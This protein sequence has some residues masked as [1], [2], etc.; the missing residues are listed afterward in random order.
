MLD[1]M[2]GFCPCRWMVKMENF[3]VEARLGCASWGLDRLE[4]EAQ[5][6]RS[7]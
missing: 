3:E 6:V 5:S 7:K 1:V 4:V 2:R